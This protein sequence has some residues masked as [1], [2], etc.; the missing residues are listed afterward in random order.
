MSF[1]T[2]SVT[3]IKATVCTQSRCI[4]KQQYLCLALYFVSLSFTFSNFCLC[5]CYSR[6]SAFLPKFSG[7][8]WPHRELHARGQSEIWKEEVL[9]GVGW[10]NTGSGPIPSSCAAKQSAHPVL[11][12]QCW[13]RNSAQLLNRGLILTETDKHLDFLSKCSATI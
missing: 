3:N 5:V 1:G 11:G 4:W 2:R 12:L 7:S 8:M 10:L 6:A 13:H 9:L